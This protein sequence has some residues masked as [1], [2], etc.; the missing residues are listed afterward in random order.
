M[1]KPLESRSAVE[2]AEFTALLSM[3]PPAKASSCIDI[4]AVAPT[5]PLSFAQIARRKVADASVTFAHRDAK[6]LTAFA[7]LIERQDFP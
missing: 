5:P 1:V 6:A 2:D 3:A 7:S 4:T